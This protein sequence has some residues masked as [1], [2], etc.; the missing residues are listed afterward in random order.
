VARLV[1]RRSGE[2]LATVDSSGIGVRSP[3]YY[4][5][6]ATART[7]DQAQYLPK[8]ANEFWE[9]RKVSRLPADSCESTRLML[10]PVLISPRS[11]LLGFL[12]S[13]TERHAG[14][15]NMGRMGRR[16]FCSACC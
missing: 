8:I 4:G 2:L 12:G 16:R 10:T 6:A 5:D 7:F 3:A 11:P 1:I 14:G 15:R 9:V 13:T